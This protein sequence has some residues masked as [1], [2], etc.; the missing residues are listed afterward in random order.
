MKISLLTIAVV[1]VAWMLLGCSSAEG[2]KE[3]KEE[4]PAPKETT[5]S[6]KSA[7]EKQ[8]GPAKKDLPKVSRKLLL[9]GVDGATWVLMD[10]LL[11]KGKL[12]HFKSLIDNGVRAP[13]KT[14]K[15]SASPMLWT[16]IATGVEP[17]KHGI[18]DF[19]IKKPGTNET[20]VP[21]SNLR[22]VNALWNILSDY[23]YTVGVIGWWATYPA[24]KVYGFV[25]SDQTDPMRGKNYL[26]ALGIT[27]KIPP[28]AD[29]LETF[30]PDLA[31]TIKPLIE[32]S[33]DVGLQHL[34]RFMNLP[35]KKIAELEG[36][37]IVDL[38][39]IV[40]IFSIA[41]LIEQAAIVSGLF[42]VEKYKPD[43]TAFYLAGLDHAAE[44]HFWKFME[45][46]KF[47]NVSKADV[48]RYGKVIEK[49][50]LYI[51]E[52]LGRL[53]ALYPEEERT[54]VVVSDHGHEANKNYDP[55]S[56]DHYNRVCSG[57]HKDAPDGILI[58]SGKDIVKGAEIKETTLLD[59]A[60]TVLAL[61]GT[62]VGRD[63]PGR[64]IDEAL[65]PAFVASHPVSK[66]ST[67]SAN[68]THSDTPVKSQMSDLLKKKLQAIGYVE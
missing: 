44:H 67:H 32:K 66:V 51:D 61:M 36:K 31:K 11:K 57:D 19:V 41:L 29:E 52:V 64:V 49:Y 40:S 18:T 42:T 17:K 10:P 2:K 27:D 58:M 5:S 7:L 48:K 55:K 20:L 22:K 25:V 60:P 4:Q 3:H 65:Q 38:E 50:Y 15:P 30:P 1:W 26:K 14:F 21:T 35:K 68:K 13:L 23:D 53:L 47:E 12:P 56:T 37:E 62:P 43:F 8:P 45:S 9:F 24:E 16:T 6:E 33:P 34:G 59:I 39:D 54:V 46:E 28:H 63:M